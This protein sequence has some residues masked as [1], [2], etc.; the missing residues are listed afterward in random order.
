MGEEKRKIL[1]CL[2]KSE[3][4]KFATKFIDQHVAVV[5]IVVT[6]PKGISADFKRRSF[7]RPR[8]SLN[9]ASIFFE[10]AYQTYFSTKLFESN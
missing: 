8:A 7:I 10:V 1:I 2:E 5:T 9:W 4:V 6:T 3:R